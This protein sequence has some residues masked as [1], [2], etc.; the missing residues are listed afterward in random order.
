MRRGVILIALLASGLPAYAGLDGYVFLYPIESSFRSDG[1]AAWYG[2]LREL[3]ASAELNGTHSVH[4]D[5]IFDSSFQVTGKYHYNLEGPATPATCSGD[6]RCAPPP[7][8]PKEPPVPG[9]EIDVTPSQG[10]TPI[11]VALNDRYEF[12]SVEKGVSFDLDA[13][14]RADR[15]AWPRDGSVAFLFRDRNGNGVPDD[16]AELFGN[17][18]R[19][20]NG[21]NAM[22]G[23]EALA[24]FDTNADGA[25]T[26]AD[27][28]WRQLALWTDTNH[29]GIPALPEISTLDA[30]RLA[31]LG[32]RY[33]WTGRRDMHGN[34]LR[35]QSRVERSGTGPRPYYDVYLMTRN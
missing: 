1:E 26:P 17:H 3:D 18:T 24:E 30:H 4:G 28:R 19:L 5:Q 32:V 22:H 14:G 35:W 12:T 7:P 16:G 6:T 25:V 34:I 31:S 2:W 20:G 8:P 11:V 21:A 9:T 27:A 13:D 10:H 23:F 33:H 29:D 15:V